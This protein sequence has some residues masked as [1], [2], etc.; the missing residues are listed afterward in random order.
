MIFTLLFTLWTAILIATW[1]APRSL[2]VGAT[3]V[4]LCLTLMLFIHHITDPLRLS[5]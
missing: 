3:I 2:A 5:F 4:A 1:L